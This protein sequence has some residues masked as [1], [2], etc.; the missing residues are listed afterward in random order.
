MENIPSSNSRKIKLSLLNITDTLTMFNIGYKYNFK[1]TKD[2]KTRDPGSLENLCG[3]FRLQPNTYHKQFNIEAQ[4]GATREDTFFCPN[5]VV[6]MIC[7]RLCLNV[8]WR[9]LI[10]SV[11]VLDNC[12]GHGRGRR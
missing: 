5:D 7:V 6:F 12:P 4:H 9:A 10:P 3:G 2:L 8:S 11:D 1:I